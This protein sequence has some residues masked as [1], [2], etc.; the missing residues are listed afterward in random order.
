VILSL[1][2]IGAFFLYLYLAVLSL[3][4]SSSRTLSHWLLFVSALCAAYWAFFS[5]FA[6]NAESLTELR[7]WFYISVFG[8]FLYFPVNLLFVLSLHM[9]SF[10]YERKC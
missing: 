2:V 10:P 3:T 6:Y 1:F 8:M 7:R 9:E 5:F 4:M